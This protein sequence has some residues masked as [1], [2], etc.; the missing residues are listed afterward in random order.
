VSSFEN[1]RYAIPPSRRRDIAKT[2]AVIDIK[3]ELESGYKETRG[4]LLAALY[5]LEK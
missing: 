5:D 1:G 4:R 2:G 3:L